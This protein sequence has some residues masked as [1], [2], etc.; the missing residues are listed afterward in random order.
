M[1]A[2]HSQNATQEELDRYAELLQQAADF[3]R[4]GETETLASM[5]DAGLPVN[6]QDAKGSSLLMLASYNGNA[7]TTRMILERGADAELRNDRGQTPL[8]GA[9][10]KGYTEIIGILLDHGADVNADN[11]GGKTPLLF[12]TMFGRFAAR[13]TLSARGGKMWRGKQS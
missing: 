10:F 5:F 8:G 7:D 4:Q 3:A 12:A 11:G 9:A 6:L 2:I 13:K 1:N